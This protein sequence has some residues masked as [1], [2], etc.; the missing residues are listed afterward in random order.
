MAVV[1]YGLI[2]TDIKGKVNG[3]TLQGGNFSKVLRTNSNAKNSKTTALSNST[4]K[5]V[6]VTSQWKLQSDADKL[7]WEAA[8][9]TYPFTDKYGNTY[10]ANGFQCFTSYNRNLLTIGY[11]ITPTPNAVFPS[12]D[13]S[14]F[15]FSS[16]TKANVTIVPTTILASTQFYLI[17]ASQAYSAGRNNNN[18]IFK[19]IT[20]IDMNGVAAIKVN[21]YYN[22]VFGNFISN[23]K[24]IFKIV[25]INPTYPFQY[26]PTIISTIIS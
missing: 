16:T 13:V 12:I 21:T 25:Q 26:F 19:L 20:A 4:N 7:L 23:S 1:K 8:A 6:S 18:P 17:Y 11:P 10:Y 3:Q 14:P 22:A 2:I 9:L 24:V 5:L 15:T